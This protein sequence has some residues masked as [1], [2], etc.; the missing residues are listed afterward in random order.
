MSPK[1]REGRRLRW[2]A[3]C[4]GFA[5]GGFF[6]GILLHQ[7]LQW[8][9]LLSLVPGIGSVA[10]QILFDGLFHALMYLIALVGLVL[11]ASSGPDLSAPGA[12]RLVF[13]N[14]LIG[15]GLW[16]VLDALVSHWALGIHRINLASA[17]PL[18]WD[19]AWL[20]L[21]GL[22]PIVAGWLLRRGPGAGA[23]A[24]RAAALGLVL[25]ISVAAPWAAL[26]PAGASSAIVIF[27]PGLTDG[28]AVNA[29]R[30]AGADL[31]WRSRGAWAVRWRGE[32]RPGLLYAEGAMLVST[33]LAGAGCLAWTRS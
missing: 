31:L 21:F 7:I 32:P 1:M 6:D 19:L 4:L 25:C 26:P 12:A 8:H 14:A 22:A 10:E 15:F 28:E 30:H 33:S 3:Y 5:L 27:R 16:H 9:H 20:A 24:G 2:S 17:N 11:L 13:A 23:T 18:L 29:V